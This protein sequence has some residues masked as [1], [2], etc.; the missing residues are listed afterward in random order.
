MPVRV[1]GLER[2]LDL[3]AGMAVEDV[4]SAE[5]FSVRVDKPFELRVVA[6]VGLD[7]RAPGRLRAF[8][9]AA[10]SAAPAAA[11]RSATTTAAPS[12]AMIS[13][14]ARPMPE[15]APVTIATRL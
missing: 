11:L 10:P 5:A 1:D 6:D 8:D 4:D 2:P 15:P 3:D 14:P 7:R 12:R 9:A 13:A